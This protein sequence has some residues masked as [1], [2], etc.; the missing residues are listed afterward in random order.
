MTIWRL[1]DEEIDAMSADERRALIRRLQLPPERV[2]PRPEIVRIHRRVRL[3]LMV[4]G[5]IVLIPWIAYLAVSLPPD[6]QAHNW[7]LTWVGFDSLLVIMMAMTAYL[8]WQRRQLLLLPAFGT[9]LLLL[10]DA[11]F[12][13]T[14]AN[15]RDVWLSIAI[16][17][18]GEIP[19]AILQI[20][21]ALLL[22]KFVTEAH[23]LA[24]P[25]VS[26]WRTK[27]PF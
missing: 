11:W 17:C 26:A 10:V 1:S 12:D 6:Y 4:G 7:P 3:T 15:P 2:L 16:A 20:T 13:I 5:S 14:T 8:G 21:G 19:L 27:L 25:E 9:G 24:D 23:P 22:F 18:V